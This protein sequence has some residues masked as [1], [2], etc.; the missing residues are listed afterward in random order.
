MMRINVELVLPF[1][2]SLIVFSGCI[3][4]SVEEDIIAE[5]EVSCEILPS[6][7][8]EPIIDDDG[9]QAVVANVRAIDLNSTDEA[10]VYTE[11]LK[12]KLSLIH[13]DCSPNCQVQEISFSNMIA[14]LRLDAA[15]FNGDGYNELILSDIGVLYPSESK[16]GK[17]MLIDLTNDSEDYQGEIVIQDIGRVTCAEAVDLDADQDLDLTLCE[18]GHLNGSVG[19]LENLGDNNWTWHKLETKPGAIEA[20]PVDMDGD[21]DYDIVSIISQLSEQIVVFWNDGTGNF[22]SEILFDA[23]TTFFGMSGINIVDIENDGDQDILFT[24]GDVLDGDFPA[25][26]NLWDYHGL[27]ILENLGNGVFDYQRLIAFTGAYDSAVFDIDSDGVE[28][29]V[30]IG[31]KPTLSMD[32]DFEDSFDYG[33]Q[34]NIAWLNYSNNSWN[35]VYPVNDID[36]PLIS[37]EVMDFDGDGNQELIAANHDIMNTTSFPKLVS[38][39]SSL[40]EVCTEIN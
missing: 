20:T 1:L 30:V 3:S 33:N 12:G 25:D 16:Q 23:T 11:P 7:S 5:P 13:G 34:P 10:L 18:F 32:R 9:E 24:N 31:F 4:Q 38:I 2:I 40:T 29:I 35:P 21:G 17:I 19:W 14:P 8:Y 36:A 15:D 22:T 27:S 6:V 37:L 28:D 26:E 39:T